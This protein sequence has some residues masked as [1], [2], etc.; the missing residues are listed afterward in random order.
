MS[1]CTHTIM[2]NVASD[3]VAFASVCHSKCSY[4][5]M[6]LLQLPNLAF[7]CIILP[8]PKNMTF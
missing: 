3:G 4:I 5:A 6:F 8:V 7:A 1:S 2:C